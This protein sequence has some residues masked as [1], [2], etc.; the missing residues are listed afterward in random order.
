MD[1]TAELKTLAEKLG[2]DLFGVA[3]LERLQGVPVGMGAR[4]SSYRPST[5]Q[6]TAGSPC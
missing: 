5:A 3:D 2:V 1:Q 4:C 6:S